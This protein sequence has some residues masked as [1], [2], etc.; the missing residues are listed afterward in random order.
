LGYGQRFVGDVAG[1]IVDEY[2][3]SFAYLGPKKQDIQKIMAAEE[4]KFGA[5]LALGM[6]VFELAMVNISSGST[7]P[8]KDTFDLYQSYGFPVEMTEELA[9]ERGVSIDRPAFEEELKKHQDLSRS[10]AAQR[11]HG[12]LADHAAAT[13]RLHTANHML[14]EAM[15]RVLGR[16]VNQRGSNITSERLR[17]DFN[18]PT[19]LTPEQIEQI[20][21]LV[22]TQLAKDLPVHFEVM[23]LEQARQEKATGV[24][25]DRYSENVKV[26]KM[27]QPGQYFSVEI[28]GGPHVP[29][30][31]QVGRLKILKEEAVA[32][33][34]RRIKAVVKDG[35]P[36]KE[37][38]QAQE[39]YPEAPRS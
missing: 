16:D 32:A 36:L 14:L 6:K 29:R 20:E 15:K 26:Y 2:V 12:G 24:F 21:T 34:I 3:G 39:E 38:E 9:K 7:L 11:F 27:G 10:G 8:T 13:V 4:E 35:T 31:G 37:G 17:L 19:K 30:T 33:G 22:N 23:P 18:Y 5:T 28:C 1:A 25:E